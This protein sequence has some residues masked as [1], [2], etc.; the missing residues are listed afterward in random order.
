MNRMNKKSR[1]AANSQ[2]FEKNIVNMELQKVE[3]G[4]SRL[5]F[6]KYTKQIWLAGLGAFSKAE[7]EGSKMFESLV[8]TGAEL[9]EKSTDLL[10]FKEGQQIEKSR[11]TVIGTRDKLE[12][13]I[14][15]GVHQSL[16]RLG[17]ATVKDLQKL[18]LLVLE[19]HKKM[20]LVI[21]ENKVFK[22][23]INEK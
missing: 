2:K 1:V 17:L 5:D 19:L 10:G 21:E 18:E 3:Y 7:E 8:Q 4:Q 11:G 13:L 9:E 20:D 6:R 15:Y 16:N 14:D 22:S 23:N 12:K